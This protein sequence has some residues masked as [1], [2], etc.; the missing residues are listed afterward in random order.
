MTKKEKI[1]AKNR[2][3]SWKSRMRSFYATPPTILLLLLGIILA[4]TVQ[5]GELFVS[6]L[7][8]IILLPKKIIYYSNES[9]NV[10]LILL[11]TFPFQ[12]CI[13]LCQKVLHKCISFWY[14]CQN[15]GLTR[16]RVHYYPLL[17]HLFDRHG[18]FVSLWLQSLSSPKN[19]FWF[20]MNLCSAPLTHPMISNLFSSDDLADGIFDLLQSWHDYFE[21]WHLDISYL[22]KALHWLKS[23]KSFFYTR[24]CLL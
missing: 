9:T 6:L 10:K 12:K 13:L 24:E 7:I 21:N 2:G 18:P 23:K 4:A 16:I 1:V 15:Q 8:I 20:K 19:S 3:W 14:H 17:V 11:R 5:S 22:E